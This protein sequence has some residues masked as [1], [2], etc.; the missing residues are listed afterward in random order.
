M[1]GTIFLLYF[2]A[3]APVTLRVSEISCR[4]GMQMRKEVENKTN[5]YRVELYSLKVRELDN[6]VCPYPLLGLRRPDR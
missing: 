1:Q 2:H 4:L 5:F 6:S 3:F